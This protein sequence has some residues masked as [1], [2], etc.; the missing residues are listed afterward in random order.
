MDKIKRIQ[1]IRLIHA[2]QYGRVCPIETGEGM[3]AT[4]SPGEVDSEGFIR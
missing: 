2:S 1:G 4:L 3:S